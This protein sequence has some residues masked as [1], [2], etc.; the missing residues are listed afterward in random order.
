MRH[1]EYTLFDTSFGR[2]G[3][4]WSGEGI[5]RVQLPDRTAAATRARLDDL[6]AAPAT[7]RPR[8]ALNA[9]K[10][11]RRHLQGAPT[12]L[13]TIPLDTTDIPPFHRDVY[14]ALRKIPGGSTVTYGELATR[15]GSPG[16]ARAVG[17]AVGAN[18]WPVIVPC[19]RV[20][21]TGGRL[22]GFSA[23]GGPDTKRRLLE[24]E[25]V[26]PVHRNGFAYDPNE[27][28]AHLCS[29]DERLGQLIAQVG[30]FGLE[31]RKGLNTYESL[32][33]AI[34]YQQLA[35]PAAAT[36]YGRVRALVPGRRLTPERVAA[37]SGPALRGAGLSRAKTL[38]VQDLTRRAGA[39]EIPAF[40]DL[41]LM[42][43]ERIV[44]TLTVVRGIGRWTVEMLLIGLGRPDVLPVSDYGIQKGFG[45]IFKRGRLPKPAEVA[46]RG[47]R[48]RPYRSVASWY[49]WRVVDTQLVVD[50]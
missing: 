36:I 38:A 15:A 44:E 4:A 20:V 21:G 2:C 1:D 49:L 50:G 30:R 29:A 32:L 37:V 27:A 6:G 7:R 9:I 35:G 39:G 14:E 40:R 45:V 10:A 46:R 43:D 28:L 22:G 41:R 19:H 33:Q 17:Q 8:W 5:T 31:L 12:E 47:E 25:G 11:L 34:V 18:P 13:S 3:I 24:L 16:A 26:Y 42:S 23:F 48:W